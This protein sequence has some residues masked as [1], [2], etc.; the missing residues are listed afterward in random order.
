MSVMIFHR[1]R[2]LASIPALLLLLVL[3]QPAQAVGLLRDADIEF[4]LKQ[5]AAP[6]SGAVGL[7]PNQVKVLLVSDS[8][9]NAF[10]IRNDAIFIHYGL[11]NKLSSAPMLQQD[12]TREA[13]HIANARPEEASADQS[14]VRYMKAAGANPQRL[15]GTPKVFSGRLK[16]AGT[17]AKRASGPLPRGSGPWQRAQDV[18]IASERAAKRK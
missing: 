6:V 13:P 9:P 8:S 12:I 17:H 1:M 3:A 15:G 16:D 11:V 7:N 10:V 5:I 4:A 18:L 2:L 14:G